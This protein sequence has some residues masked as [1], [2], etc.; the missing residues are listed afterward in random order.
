MGTWEGE[1]VREK[2]QKRKKEKEGRVIILEIC[3]EAP[4]PA[5]FPH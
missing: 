4:V 5:N 3:K 1:K 2:K